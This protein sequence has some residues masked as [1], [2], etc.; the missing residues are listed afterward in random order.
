[1]STKV[2]H[3]TAGEC[4]RQLLDA[5]NSGAQERVQQALDGIANLARGCSSDSQELEFRDLLAGLVQPISAAVPEFLS[6]PNAPSKQ[7][8]MQMLVHVAGE[9]RI[10]SSD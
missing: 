3:G 1:M 4:A 9:C 6:A 5:L 10:S 8:V 7:V 2:E